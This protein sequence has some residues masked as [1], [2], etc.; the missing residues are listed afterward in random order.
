MKKIYTLLTLASLLTAVNAQTIFQK[1]LGGNNA[2]WG[3]AVLPLADG[4]FM[5]AGSTNSM[6]AG[7][8]DFYLV[9]LNAN[10]D[11]LWTKTYGGTE[12]D[13]ATGIQQTSDGGF[14]LVGNSATLS[15]AGTDVCLV[16]TDSSGNLLWAK[17]YGGAEAD[18][19]YAV[20]QTSDGGFIAV[21]N[22]LSISTDLTSDIF[23]IKTNAFGRYHVDKSVCRNLR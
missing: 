18:E 14:I 13:M 9:Q 4:R 12:N 10:G 1:T 23:V 21:G 16:R 22:T 17:N 3:N 15:A 11:T 8:Y 5:L 19:G 20:L 6:G 7:N 2:D